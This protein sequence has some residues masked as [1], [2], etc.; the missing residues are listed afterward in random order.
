MNL[1]A[2]RRET[3]IPASLGPGDSSNHDYGA[4]GLE[5]PAALKASRYLTSRRSSGLP[6]ARLAAIR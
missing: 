1:V 6:V 3:Q 2:T 4:C 5:G